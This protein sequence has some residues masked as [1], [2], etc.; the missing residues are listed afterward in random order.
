M[1]AGMCCKVAVEAATY[2]IDKPY[3][4]LIPDALSERVLPGMRVTVPFGRGNRSAEG[5]VLDVLDTHPEGRLK[6]LSCLLDEEPVVDAAGLRLALW[7]RERYYCTVFDAVKAM[8]PAGLYYNLQD[9]FRLAPE[10][11]MPEEPS[12]QQQRVLELVEGAGGS[13]Q[14]R[15][16]WA[17]FGQTSPA[18]AV[19]QLLEQGILLLETSA[20]RGVG[21]RSEEVAALAVSTEDA[22]QM[23]GRDRSKRRRQV[24]ELLCATGQASLKELRYYTGATRA[25][26]KPLEEKGIITLFRREVFRRP[27]PGQVNRQ[28]CPELNREQQQACDGLAAMMDSGKPGCA[29]LYGVTG[30]GK[31]AVYIN[32][33][34]RLLAEGKSALVLVPEIGLTPQLLTQFT[35]QFGDLVAVLHSSLPAG[36]RY[37]EWKRIRRGTARVVIGTRSAIFAPVNRLGL[38]ILDEEQE[39][40][41]K[42]ENAPRYH[43]REIAQYRCAQEN[44]L[45]VLG[46]ATPSV[47]SRYLAD[48][49]RY[50]LFSL[51]NRFNGQALPEVRIAD[52]R[53]ELRQGNG[54]ALSGVLREELQRNLDRGEQSILLLNRRGSSRMVVCT[55]CG[56]VPECER[57]SVKLTY[58]AANHRLMCHYCGHS[59]PEPEYC[60][61]CGGALS[62]QGW[63]TQ[64]VEEELHIVFPG[65]E[66]LRMDADT[67][68]ATHTHRE[69]L[70]R[71]REERIPILIGTQ[72][73]A[74][75]LD[76]PNVTLAA[77]I[78]ADLNLYVDDF[79]AAERTF[80]L[81]TQVVGRAGR[82]EHPGRA[83]IQTCTPNHEVIRT[84]AR[85]DYDQFYTRE[86]AL[87]ESLGYPPFGDLV[88]FTVSGTEEGA[89]LRGSMRLRE[90]LES[91]QGSPALE[92]MTFRILGPAPA[93][94]VKING[95]YRYCI[96]VCG[97]YNRLMRNMTARL[98]HAAAEDKQNRGIT[99][100]ADVNPMD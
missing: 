85:Q 22:A 4:Y 1:A 16:L 86:I 24:V 68:S 58:H 37:D 31:T 61:E 55:Q 12:P 9:W 81:L 97:S 56:W 60:P 88:V 48:V 51:P 59:E 50:H 26:L 96:T 21:D 79:R 32:L 73:V 5:I 7:M 62:F 27:D 100:S 47:E 90:G 75:G 54:S 57:C 40:S 63:G 78:D 66:V 99:V 17:A 10:A 28:S 41:Y 82:G 43:A 72:M 89:V 13:M 18:R 70:N 35:A 44:A 38:V 64:R 25:T 8:L 87:R 11:E 80:S 69:M 53:E 19:S 23:V 20:Q 34:H 46:S 93:N 36:E 49:G 95:R 15:E 67:I 52:M 71:F 2:A 92:G 14:R 74:K 77:V 45:L 76:F 39:A 33:I 91:W 30:S 98:L 42:S 84:A 29:L 65:A 3:T 6:W 94:I 83:V